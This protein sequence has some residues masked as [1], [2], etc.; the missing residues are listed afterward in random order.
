VVLAQVFG[1]PWSES[2]ESD[3]DTGSSDS[4]T[5]VTN[6]LDWDFESYNDEED[7]MYGV[8]N[9]GEAPV[10]EQLEGGSMDIDN[11]EPE[12]NQQVGNDLHQAR[13]VR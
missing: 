12:N 9:Y 6:H 8:N 11:S 13:E 7:L 2:S 3:A 4:D 5:L 10:P 1:E